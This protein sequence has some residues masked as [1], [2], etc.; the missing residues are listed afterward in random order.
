MLVSVIIPYFKKKDFIKKTVMSV[1]NQ[2]YQT[3]EIII[4]DDELT[5]DSKNVLKS[6][7]S[8]DSRIIIIDNK[9][10]IGAGK[11]RNIGIN[12][13]RGKYL[14][15]IDSDDLWLEK[16]LEIQINEMEKHNYSATHT[17]YYIIDKNEKK[18][19]LRQSKNLYFKDLIKSCDIGLSTVIIKKKICNESIKFSN[20]Q[21]K[22]DYYFWLKI[23]E[24]GE[25]FKIID[26]PLTLWRLTEKSLSSSN[27][28][29]LSDSF[30][31]YS[32]F[33]KNIFL[34]LYRVFI[35]S[36]NYIKKKIDDH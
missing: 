10:N 34:I 3:F 8:L 1:L 2:T 11:S 23:T 19:S 24:S 7:K 22:E 33:E 25:F 31:V 28:Q 36:I 9:K 12:Y 16:K 35:L 30:K 26:Q 18:L 5:L 13:S 20:F 17:P 29:K 6:I 21:T 15:F 4:I 32:N 14:A 27:L